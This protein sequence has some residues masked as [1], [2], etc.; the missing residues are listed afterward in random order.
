MKSVVS[1]VAAALLIG[2]VGSVS[3]K[4]DYN[5]VPA[6]DP[7]YQGCIRYAN[8]NYEGGNEKSP[9]K[10]QNKAQAYCE[11]MWNE[12]PDN[13]RGNLAKFGETKKGKEINEICEKYSDWGS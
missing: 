6:N 3:A 7:Q 5:D 8:K 13:F 12:T 2:M 4:G 11:C 10:G 1:F 9:I